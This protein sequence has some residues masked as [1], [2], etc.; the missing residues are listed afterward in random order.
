MTRATQGRRRTAP[1][2][3]RCW[4]SR[5]FR[6][7]ACRP[8]W[9]TSPAPRPLLP[10]TSRHTPSG[11]TPPA[12]SNLNLE[13]IG[14]TS[15]NL[16]IVPVGSRRLDHGVQ[17]ERRAHRRRRRRL[18]QRCDGQGRTR[19]LFVPLTPS[20]VLDTRTGTGAPAAALAQDGSIDVVIA[21]KWRCTSERCL[22]RRHER[23]VR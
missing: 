10:D 21:G 9:S 7:P 23:D 5:A 4:A 6:Q 19:G 1:S 2:A 15:S 12:T 17:P 14:G 13:M 22:G 11:T 3:S 18:V 8:C 20:R 16:A